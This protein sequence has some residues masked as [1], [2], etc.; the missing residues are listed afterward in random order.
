M[1][2][3]V[4]PMNRYTEINPPKDIS[5]VVRCFWQYDGHSEDNRHTIFPNGCFELFMAFAHGEAVSVLLS[6]VRTKPFEVDI[7]AGI[8]VTGVRFLLPAAEYTDSGIA[9]VVDATRELDAVLDHAKELSCLSF[10]EK[11]ARITLTLRRIIAGKKIEQ[12]KLALLN[13]AYIPDI[14]IRE[15]SETIHWSGKKINR[16][17]SARFGVSLKTFLNIVRLRSSFES[18]KEGVLYP[19]QNY[20][21]QSHYI[22]EVKKYTGTSPKALLKNENDLFLQFSPKEEP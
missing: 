14:S 2:R 18:V 5:H 17:F 3:H 4:H 8:S 15:I 7:P 19:Q 16:Y 11:A 1:S 20:Y 10:E 12:D 6:G 13:M 9:S 22:K 21:D